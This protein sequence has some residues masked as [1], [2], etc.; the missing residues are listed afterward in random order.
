MSDALRPDRIIEIGYAFRSSKVLLS[1]VELGVFSAL[2]GSSLDAIQLSERVGIDNRCACDF[3]DAL[4]A[5]GLL[6]RSVDGHYANT[7]AT[8]K[9]LDRREPSYIGDEFDHL[10]R[11]GYPLW[12]GLTAALRRA[13]GS[14]DDHGASLYDELYS[15]ARERDTFIKGMTASSRLAAEAIAVKF[16][17]GRFRTV[18]DVGCAEGGLLAEIARRHPHIAGTGFDLP[19]LRRPFEDF[20]GKHG[21]QSRLTFKPGD[22]RADP[23][24]TADV[25]ILGRI[26]HNWDL[27]TKQMLLR[28]ARDALVAHGQIVVYE[29]FIDDERRTSAAGLL[30]SLNMLVVSPRGYDFTVTDCIA[31]MSEVGF[32]DMHLEP[33]GTHLSMI[34]ATRP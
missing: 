33:L 11:R 23:L 13:S 1:A 3:F 4:V 34:V 22:F 14:T 2:A 7:P 29:R 16:D 24:P 32:C 27:A 8:A 21:L 28:K 26:L 10:N 12:T 20:V 19:L 9:F 15:D 25:V 5:L 18:V 31:W 6:A 30:A 17:W